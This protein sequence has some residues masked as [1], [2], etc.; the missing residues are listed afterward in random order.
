MLMV[1]FVSFRQSMA[2]PVAAGVFVIGATSRPDL[3][4][5]ALLRPGRLDRLLMCPFPNAQDRAAIMKALA[6]KIV[7][8]GQVSIM[9]CLF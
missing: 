4:D 9:P 1:G 8:A 3:L 6:H 5:A 7:F 2:N